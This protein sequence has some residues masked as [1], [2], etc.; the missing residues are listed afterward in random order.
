MARFE[1]VIHQK[2]RSGQYSVHDAHIGRAIAN[3]L[4]GGKLMYPAEVSEQYILNVEREAFLS[5][6][7]RPETLA[8][9]RH[10]LATGKPLKN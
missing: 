1:S 9:I 3:I 2:L 7:S 5:L 4:C 10:M 8:R 6:A